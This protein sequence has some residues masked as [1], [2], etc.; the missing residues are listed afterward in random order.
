MSTCSD[1]Q[2]SFQFQSNSPKTFG[3]IWT[4]PRETGVEVWMDPCYVRFCLQGIRPCSTVNEKV[5]GPF[6]P[7]T[8]PTYSQRNPLCMGKMMENANP[9]ESYM[10]KPY[11]QI[12]DAFTR[13]TIG[14]ET[15]Q[16]FRGKF[17]PSLF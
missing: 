14:T 1:V 10:S 11:C 4:N 9:M 3:I 2:L 6:R 5:H 12:V 13:I 7:K 16:R 8:A 17:R 15:N